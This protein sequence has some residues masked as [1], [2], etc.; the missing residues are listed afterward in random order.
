MLGW[1][2]IP[3]LTMKVADRTQVTVDSCDGVV[4]GAGDQISEQRFMGCWQGL[5]PVFFTPTCEV[6]P[7]GGVI[8]ARVERVT[9][10]GV[11]VSLREQ[12]GKIGGHSTSSCP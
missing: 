12:G 7:I 10:G 6:F 8:D 5:S 11:L 1:Q 9:A 2:F 3:L 4:F